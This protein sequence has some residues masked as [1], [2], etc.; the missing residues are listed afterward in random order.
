VRLLDRLQE[1]QRQVATL[2]RGGDPDNLTFPRFA[3]DA[4]FLL[5]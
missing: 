3:L 2:Y 4:A 5:V 1:R